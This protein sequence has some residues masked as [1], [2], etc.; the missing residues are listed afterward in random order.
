[1]TGDENPKCR[2]IP[3]TMPKLRTLLALTALLALTSCAN[4]RPDVPGYGYDRIG[5]APVFTPK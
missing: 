2:Y 1:M 5:G 4:R 3:G